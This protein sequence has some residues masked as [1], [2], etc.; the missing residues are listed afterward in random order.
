MLDIV[1]PAMGFLKSAHD[2]CYDA[3]VEGNT[4]WC[5]VTI[6]ALM[7]TIAF[8]YTF[9]I[10]PKSLPS[11]TIKQDSTNTAKVQMISNYYRAS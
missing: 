5:Y 1:W 9:S 4:D 10:I 11:Q 3:V 6:H 7:T 8:T 2:R